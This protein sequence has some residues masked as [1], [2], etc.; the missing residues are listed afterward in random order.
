MT[1]SRRARQRAD[2]YFGDP[3]A[4]A[5]RERILSE[6][7]RHLTDASSPGLPPDALVWPI[8]GRITS[9][10]GDRVGR[11]HTGIDIAAPEGAPVS[12]VADGRVVIAEAL[13]ELGNTIVLDHGQGCATLYAHHRALLVAAG[14]NVT[15]G[16]CIGLAGATGRATGPHLHFETRLGGAPCDPASLLPRA[17][18][19]AE[20]LR[21]DTLTLLRQALVGVRDV[22]LVGTTLHDNAGDSLIWLGQLAAFADLGI[23]VRAVVHPASFDRRVFDEAP[24]GA[25]VL[26]SGGGNFGDVWPFVQRHREWVLR[27]IRGRRIVQLPQSLHFA[28]PASEGV[29]RMQRLLAARDDVLLTWRD[30]QSLQAALRLFPASE[31]QLIPDVSF[32]RRPP[33]TTQ[34][35]RDEI[36]WIARD[37]RE[38]AALRN[39]TIASGRVTDWHLEGPLPAL[40]REA[41]WLTARIERRVPWPF[42]PRPRIVLHNRSALVTASAAAQ[43]VSSARVVVTDRLH[44][45]VLCTML[46]VPHVVFDGGYGKIRSFLETWP[47]T[48]GLAQLASSPDDAAARADRLLRE[49][50]A[51]ASGRRG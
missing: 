42:G 18:D 27:E 11:F 22:V 14:D 23:R 2:V 44:G 3:D 26:L 28:D 47:V 4:L 32:A 45:H 46:A 16:Q 19:P 51:S 17:G 9:R 1:A 50:R 24:R 10:F 13:P 5:T 38:G 37:D 31:S 35:A 29:E 36:L 40:M 20:A 48:A 8:S 43:L 15:R 25:V 30:N 34:R 12:A 7:I 49:T 39:R 33:H 6:R 41:L 21:L